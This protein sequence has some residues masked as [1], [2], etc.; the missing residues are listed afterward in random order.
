MMEFKAQELSGYSVSSNIILQDAAFGLVKFL[1]TLFGKA[2]AWYE[3]YA[4]LQGNGVG[5][6]LGIVN[7]PA[8]VT[9]MSAGRTVAGAVFT[10]FRNATS[11][12]GGAR[13]DV[14]NLPASEVFIAF[15][16]AISGVGEG[17]CEKPPRFSRPFETRSA[18]IGGR[19]T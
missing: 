4:F 17:C 12:V 11:G 7:A 1:M 2:V 10:E 19:N 13:N 16:N 6:P 3:E 5:K 9:A 18:R 8:T 15:R 14:R